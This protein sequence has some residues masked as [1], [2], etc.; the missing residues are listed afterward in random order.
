M[1]SDFQPIAETATIKPSVG[2]VGKALFVLALLAVG[3]LAGF[4]T[5]SVGQ[6]VPL[7]FRCNPYTGRGC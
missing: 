4:Q 5:Q 6:S 1:N 7:N 2:I 3:F